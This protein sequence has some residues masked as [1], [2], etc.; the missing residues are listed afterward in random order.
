MRALIQKDLREN[1]KLALLGLL[2]FSLVLLQSYQS[3]ITELTNLL[4]RKMVGLT[5]ALQP[6]LSSTLRM[7]A[8]FFCALFGA[9]IGWLQ[10]RNEA[11]RDLWA[12][13]IH[14]PVT[15]TEIFWGKTIAG[16][17]LY[18]FGAGLPLAVL[19]AVARWPGHVAAP[20][21]WAMVLPLA[22]IFLTGLAYYFAGLLTG[23]RQARWYASRGFGFGLAIITSLGVFASPQ[24]WLSLILIAFAV[25]VLATAA[26]GSYRSGGFYR[27]QPVIGRLALAA[28][29]TAGCGG[30]LF[31]G[32]GLLGDLVVNPLSDHS[33]VYSYYQMSK[34]GVIYKLTLRDNELLK[35]EDLEGHPLLDPKTGLMMEEKE[36]DKRAAWSFSVFS[37]F[38][39]RKNQ[40]AMLENASFFSLV[41]ITDKTLWFLDRQG[42]LVGYDGRTRNYIGRLDP[43][44][45]NGHVTSEPWLIQPNFGRFYNP[46]GDRSWRLLATAK[47]VYRVDFKGRAMKPIFALSNDDEIGGFAEERF[48]DEDSQNYCSMTT[49]KTV[50]LLDPAGRS[51][52]SAPY[53]PGFVEYPTVELSF[54][55][56]PNHFAIWFNPDKQMNQD[57]G[58][59]MPIHVLWLGPEQA[60]TK[61]AELPAL[62]PNES[63]SWPDKL[64]ATLLPPP[65]QVALDKNILSPWNLFGFAL[66]GLSAVIGWALARR[67][68]FSTTATV[69]WTLFVFLSGIT[70]LLTLLCVQEWPAREVCPQCKKLRA[71]DRQS[72]E[73]CQSPFPPPEKNG[74][75]IFGP[76]VKDSA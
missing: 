61:S 44:D 49:R 51:I 63:V 30:A 16:L 57:A 68:N 73:H 60:M 20:F 74:T 28:A 35:L 37:R 19:A 7:E 36:F 14:R 5:D 15:R 32:M 67:Y 64:E 9:G 65:A 42:E 45:K 59:T 40:M 4:G 53:Q 58:W 75:E 29:M 34:D 33:S 18:L 12:F 6:L 22:A 8:A 27:G 26:W 31:V 56:P 47:G 24:F 10:T 66:A 39:P 2:I 3:S 38:K 43:R 21:E 25:V 46:Y 69:G 48:G 23:L 76:L 71:V 41:N 62:R 70:G 50:C 17:C 11:H 55:N 13:L 52:F 1:L 54:L 72:C